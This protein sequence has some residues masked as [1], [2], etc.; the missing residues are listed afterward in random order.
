MGIASLGLTSNCG[1]DVVVQSSRSGEGGYFRLESG[2]GAA[3]CQEGNTRSQVRIPA[4]ERGKI[5]AGAEPRFDLAAESFT[6]TRFPAVIIHISTNT[7]HS[8][9]AFGMERM[10]KSNERR[11]CQG[12]VEMWNIGGVSLGFPRIRTLSIP[13]VGPRA[14]SLSTD[15]H[16]RQG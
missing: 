5:P 7:Q 2:D 12:A 13:A 1:G 10:G 9:L 14:S 8:H 16:H 6:H 3:T 4:S 11:Q 15:V